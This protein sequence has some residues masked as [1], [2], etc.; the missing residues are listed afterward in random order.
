[1]Q[2]LRK[3]AE[4]REIDAKK[5]NDFSKYVACGQAYFDI[6]NRNPEAPE[7]DEVLYNAGVCFEEG[8]S[9][10]AAI[11]AFNL[12]AEVLP[13]FSKITAKAIARL[14]KAYGDIA[15]YDRASDKLRAVR[16]EVRRREGRLRRDER[17]GVLPQGHR[18]RRQ[19]RSKTR[20]ISSR[21]SR[22]QEAAVEAA[23]AMLLAQR[24]CTRSRVIP[25]W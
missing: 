17:R 7:N 21:R 12:L 15:Y 14:G 11:T 19:G 20:S 16:Q 4:Q 10:S 22:P 18:R 9:I 1:M 24:R 25:T 3:E 5:N 23:A 2:A 6:Y 13:K 8:K